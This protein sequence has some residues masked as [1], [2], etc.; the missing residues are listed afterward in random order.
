MRELLRAYAKAEM[1]RQGY[2]KVNRIMSACWRDF[3]K[4]FTPPAKRKTIRPKARKGSA[5]R[6]KFG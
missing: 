5:V 1:Q 3:L 2:T 4:T 6:R